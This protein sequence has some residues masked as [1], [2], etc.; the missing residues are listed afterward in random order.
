MLVNM[1]DP[2]DRANGPG[3][4]PTKHRG[5]VDMS[6]DTQGAPVG[7]SHR[8]ARDGVVRLRKALETL[9]IRTDQIQKITAVADLSGGYHVRMGNWEAESAFA[10][11][12]AVEE[13][14]EALETLAA[15]ERQVSS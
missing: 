6:E 8:R 9:D 1:K 13:L 5:D 12:D 7:V 14:H 15:I 3:A 10:L 2:R 11:A 4:W